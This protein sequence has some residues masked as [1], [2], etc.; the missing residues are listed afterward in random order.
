MDI[1][2]I[3]GAGSVICNGPFAPGTYTFEVQATYTFDFQPAGMRVTLMSDHPVSITVA[4]DLDGVNYTQDVPLGG[5]SA[6]VVLDTFVTNRGET[7][8]AFK[9]TVPPTNPAA[10]NVILCVCASNNPPYHKVACHS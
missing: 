10:T 5:S 4:C 1:N 7:G 9:I 8:K 3:P 6:S 2:T